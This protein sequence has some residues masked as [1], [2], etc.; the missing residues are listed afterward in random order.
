MT[1]M[2]RPRQHPE[3]IGLTELTQLLGCAKPTANRYTLR[4]EFPQPLRLLRGRLWLR[5]DVEA[6]AKT[7][8]PLKAGRRRKGER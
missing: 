6:W 3:L 1:C 7:T 4:P 8:L 5:A 2:A